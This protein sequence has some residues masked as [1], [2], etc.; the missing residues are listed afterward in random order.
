MSTRAELEAAL[1]KAEADWRR[2]SEQLDKTQAERTR[3]NE[4]WVLAHGE[5][6]DGGSDR[7][8]AG[9]GV[10][11]AFAERRKAVADRRSADAAR[12]Q[13]NA[14]WDQALAARRDARAIY[15]RARL[16]LEELERAN[17]KS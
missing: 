16:A 2:A 14:D 12:D 8:G 1:V 3:A 11:K 13:A 4:A 9:V 5:R 17:G 7:R 15:D 6:R 10:R